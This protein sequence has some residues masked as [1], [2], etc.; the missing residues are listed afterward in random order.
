MIVPMTSVLQWLVD[1]TMKGSVV[2]LLVAAMQILIGRRLD[3]RWRH[4]LWLLVVLRLAMPVAPSSS[5]SI[6]NLFPAAAPEVPQMRV[7]ATSDNTLAFAVSR[8]PEL[9]RWRVPAW[10]ALRWL[11]ALWLIGVTI[12]LLRVAVA[13]IRVHRAVRRARREH[14]HDAGLH[15]AVD[16]ARRTLG[17]K[18]RV[19]VV[20]CSM[21]K[22][23]AIHGLFRPTLL[24]P[25]RFS[26]SFD[27]Q[28]VRHVVLHEL[29]HLRRFDVA[30]NWLLSF[31]QAL[32]W[33]NPFV[34]FATSRIAEERELA[35]DE[36][37]LSCL[38]EEERHRYGRTMLKLLEQFR[39][40]AP[41]P[42][43]VGILY[44]RNKMRRR[45]K[46]IASFRSRPR[47]SLLF[48]AAL[49]LVGAVGLTDAV[50]GERRMFVKELD[51]AS[52]ALMER[53][54]QR[55]SIELTNA[56]L[57]ELLNAV[58]N[59]TG[60]TFAQ[61]PDLATSKA[62][63]AR[64]TLKADNVPAHCVLMESLAPFG[65]APK[66]DGGVVTIGK[67]EHC[68]GMGMKMRSPHRAGHS[69]DAAD[70]NA[71]KVERQVVRVT[72][73]KAHEGDAAGTA[74]KRFMIRKDGKGGECTIS[75]DGLSRTMKIVIDDGD[76]R[77]E[78]TLKLDITGVK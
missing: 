2:I 60:V 4:A 15:A 28:E 21:V 78:G 45:L 17:I 66:P 3:A 42:A 30:V 10:P 47:Y 53:L 74:N 40:V 36:L 32:H 31:V 19:H 41:V 38:E 35:C 43:L 7:M 56:S 44:S 64:F 67:G 54:D 65:M 59:K 58:S 20:E 25:A 6:F 39:A 12:A 23:P 24:L 61:S 55:V 29:W 37:A 48:A 77:S 57:G 46:M 75:G 76:G 16:E 5:W 26:Q 72:E 51:P 63:Q 68:E 69:A 8:S 52:M 22:A 70:D 13:S 1:S 27:R 18:R 11:I 14:P 50:G 62:Q 34:W 73:H 71:V 49:V 33:F 9:L